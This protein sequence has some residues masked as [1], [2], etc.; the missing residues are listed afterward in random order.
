M[1][2]LAR[3]VSRRLTTRITDATSGFRAFGPRAIATFSRSYPSAYLS[4][5]VET[6]L[7]AA[8]RGLVVVEVT[9]EMNERVTG[10]PSTGRWRSLYHLMRVVLVVALH[11]VRYPVNQR[12]SL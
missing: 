5:T 10:A 2:L 12:G 3:L 1:R 11:R 8:D 4:D 9:A 6:L 7:L